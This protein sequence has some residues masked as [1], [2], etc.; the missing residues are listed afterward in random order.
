LTAG[1][2][3]PYCAGRDGGTKVGA[4]AALEAQ[5]DLP[6]KIVDRKNVDDKANWGNQIKA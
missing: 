1:R 6:G 2:S 4:G 5:S 3:R